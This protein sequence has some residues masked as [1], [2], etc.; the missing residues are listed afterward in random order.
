MTELEVDDTPSPEMLANDREEAACMAYGSKASN[1]AELGEDGTSAAKMLASVV[2]NCSNRTEL[3]LA[4]KPK[5]HSS[6]N[7][8]NHTESPRPQ[9]SMEHRSESGSDHTELRQPRKPMEHRGDKGSN[10]TESRR[11][12]KSMEHRSNNGSN[13]IELRQPRKLMEHRSVDGIESRQSRQPMEHR[14]DNEVDGIPLPEVLANDLKEAVCAQLTAATPLVRLS[15][16]KA[17]RQWRRC[18]PA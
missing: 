8:T 7:G 5:E 1:K 6:D 15:L 2:Q 9:K 11:P 4:R 10:H 14:S 18:L 3:R 12:R 16:G 13:H 17:A